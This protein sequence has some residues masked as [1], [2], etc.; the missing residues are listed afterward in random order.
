M[1][2]IQ[3]APQVHSAERIVE[4]IVDVLGPTELDGEAREIERNPMSERETRR[5]MLD[6]VEETYRDWKVSPPPETVSTSVNGILGASYDFLDRDEEDE[7]GP[8][9]IRVEEQ[10]A[11][12]HSVAFLR[13]LAATRGLAPEHVAALKSYLESNVVKSAPVQ[14]AAHVR[15]CQAKPCKKI[16]GKEGWTVTLALEGALEAALQLQ[17][18]ALSSEKR[19]G[20]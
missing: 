14:L 10:E 13:S 12:G 17:K 7:D 18:G 5:T 8:R 9:I 3:L 11:G 2:E 4:Q 16:E 6:M 19:R 20:S 15:H 1:E